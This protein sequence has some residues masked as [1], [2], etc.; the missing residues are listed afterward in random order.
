MV[1]IM[2]LWNACWCQHN[3]TEM[4]YHVSL[5]EFIVGI[6]LFLGENTM[7]N[8]SSDAPSVPVRKM[9]FVPKIPPRKPSNPAVVKME[10]P[11]TKDEF[12]DKKLLAKLNRAKAN[13]TFGRKMPKNERNGASSKIAFGSGG[14]SLARSFPRGPFSANQYQDGFE[15][16]A[17]KIEKEYAEP[18]DYSHSYYP[19][20]LPL[21]RPYSGNSEILD[22][23]EF[24]EAS[25]S[26]SLDEAQINPAE[27]LRLLKKSE[28]PHMLFLQMPSTLPMMKQPTAEAGTKDNIH[29]IDRALKGCK[30]EDLPGGY[31]GKL[32]VYKSGKIKMK[33]GDA[34]FD[35]S[36][37]VKCVFAQD[38]AVINTKEKHC[39]ILGEINQR[40]VVTPDVDALL[41]QIDDVG[42]S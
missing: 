39:C 4:S 35:V 38:A 11:E 7:K 20:A 27:E 42:S 22:E 5:L 34:L 36:P 40:A 13:D 17:P 37:G 3:I 14:S 25:A 19:V 10:P 12:I 6:M 29:K 18:W 15:A 16:S 32:M 41:D 33:I 24:G 31:I 2:D 21:R 9:K 23:E 26:S 30:L 28:E 8:E 1:Q